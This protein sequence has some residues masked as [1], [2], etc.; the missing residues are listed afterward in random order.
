M[1]GTDTPA[2]YIRLAFMIEQH[3]P[4]TVDAYFGPP[5]LQAQAEAGDSLPLEALE[6]FALSLGESIANDPNLSPDRRAYLE[7]EWRAMQTTIQI[8]QGK[9]PSIV[10]EVRLLYGV[11]PAW[12][13]ER[14]FEE[15]HYTL[16][17]T[18]PGAGPL[19]ERLLGFRERSRIPIE[20]ALTIIRRL[21]ADFRNRT[22]RRFSLPADDQ[23]DIS[24]VTDQPWRAY[25]WYLG[26][27][28]SRIE[29]NQ[30]HPMELWDFPQLVAHEAY[31][32]HHT[33]FAIKETK[34]YLGEGRLEHSINLSNTP[35]ALISEGIAQNALQAI[36][37]ESEIAEILAECYSQAGLPVSDAERAM[38]LVQANRQLERVIDNQILLLYRDGA[39][40]SDAMD[41]GIRYSLTTADDEERSLRFFK[42]PLSRSYT[43]NYTLGRELIAQYLNRAANRQEA[44]QRLLSEPFTPAQIGASVGSQ[45]G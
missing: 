7:E 21:L 33:E 41:Y 24:F 36:A 32:G 17:Q 4:G 44:F 16:N 25:N 37:S 22:Q 13:D 23:F 26:E 30:D 11:T 3:F 15:A 6:D 10:D 34:L 43:Y 42:D 35:S 38:A 40:D 18:L 12:V 20:T 29:I 39:P 2:D 1:S 9:A 27:R 31:P 28:K 8:L 45:T 5:E 14:V 19:R